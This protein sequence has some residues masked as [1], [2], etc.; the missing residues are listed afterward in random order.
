MCGSL[1]LVDATAVLSY[2]API[3]CSWAC[4][5]MPWSDTASV[6][7]PAHSLFSES[8]AQTFFFSSF[9]LLDGIS[10]TLLR[11]TSVAAVLSLVEILLVASFKKRRFFFRKSTSLKVQVSTSGFCYLHHVT[12]L[13][14]IVAFACVSMHEVSSALC[15]VH[16]LLG[17]M[18][19]HAKKPPQTQD[20]HRF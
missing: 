8:K 6:S 2:K 13:S 5:A 4:H 1:I 20:V 15:K 7:L 12:E 10:P 11:S 18:Q 16:I 3:N 9:V 14:G 17:T 19:N